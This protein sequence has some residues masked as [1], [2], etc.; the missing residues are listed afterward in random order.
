MKKRQ[1]SIILM[2][3][4]MITMMVIP[5]AIQAQTS[6]K[7]VKTNPT[8]PAL[9]NDN[10][11]KNAPKFSNTAEREQWYRENVMV[12]TQ[13]VVAE[14]PTFPVKK[15]SGNPEADEADYQ[16][17][18]AEWYKQQDVKR[19]AE[20]RKAHVMERERKIQ[21]LRKSGVIIE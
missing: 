17:R 5:S 13:V 7:A 12:K 1:P 21:E 8:E 16:N 2:I 11:Y 3:C 10:P 15:L 20:E 6:A 14:D 18:K 4:A 9:N 19:E